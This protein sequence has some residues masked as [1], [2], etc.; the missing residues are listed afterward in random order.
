MHDEQM[1][2]GMQSKWDEDTIRQHVKR[3]VQE[4]NIKAIFTFDEHGV[5]YHLNHRTIY[6][7]L[8]QL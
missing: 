5:S 2:D 7:A 1:I 8:T 6:Q 4:Q 3:Y